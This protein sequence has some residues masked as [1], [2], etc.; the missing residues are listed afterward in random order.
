MMRTSE[1]AAKQVK[2]AEF[3]PN[4]RRV[5]NFLVSLNVLKLNNQQAK[6]TNQRFYDKKTTSQTPFLDRSRSLQSTNK[7]LTF[8]S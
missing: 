3:F 2:S 8:F 4:T 6:V 5:L 1:F 7:G